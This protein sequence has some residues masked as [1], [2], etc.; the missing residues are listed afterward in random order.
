MSNRR[1][2]FL[3]GARDTIPLI[4]AAIPFGIVYGALAQNAGLSVWATQAMSLFV[5]AG[6]SQFVAALL[7]DSTAIAVIVVTVFVV[8]LRHMLYS[9][10]LMP[11]MVDV[12]QRQRLPMAFWLTD[13]TYAVVASRLRN[14]SQAQDFVPYYLGSAIFMY[15][16]W[17]L[18]TWIG[19]VLG[20]SVPDL[21]KWGLDVAMVV[22][23]V[24]IV[25][26]LL[27]RRAHWACA[28]TAAVS[29]TLTYHWPH[30]TGLL[31]SSFLAI[32]VGVFVSFISKRNHAV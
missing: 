8:N 32:A 6:S 18:C 7:F 19:I 9:A 26:P 5:F 24:G 3:N 11:Q 12:P 31:F 4:V 20:R 28:I 16:N 23:F 14:G 25:V 27:Q 17:Q 29:A 2:A 1:N 15:A 30:Q 22:A 13:E 10:S 21:T